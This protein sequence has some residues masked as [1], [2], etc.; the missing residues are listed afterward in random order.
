MCCHVVI[1]LRTSK[2]SF[3]WVACSEAPS[4]ILFSVCCFS[5]WL[6]ISS[7]QEFSPSSSWEGGMSL[8][9]FLSLTQSYNMKVSGHSTFQ[10]QERVMRKNTPSL[11]ASL[12]HVPVS[13]MLQ[14]LAHSRS[15]CHP[16]VFHSGD[17]FFS[18]VI[19]DFGKENQS[20]LDKW[21]WRQQGLESSLA[22]FLE[23]MESW[24][25]K[26]VF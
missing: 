2:F 11:Q 7:C 21:Q 12:F 18:Y 25:N 9:S 3:T 19:A 10:K 4:L 14:C 1:C 13:V 20:T 22:V 15:I 5:W 23:V 8:C 6:Q 17:S 26:A 16:A 24:R